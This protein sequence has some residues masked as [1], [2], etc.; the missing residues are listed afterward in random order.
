M[1]ADPAKPIVPVILSGGSGTQLWPLSRRTR[2]KQMLDLAG[3]GTMLALTVARV[4]DAELF[5]PPVLV[6][7]ADQAEAV[8]QALP[9]RAC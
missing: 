2:P 5:A 4:E 6:A 9:K 3:G 7:G 1:S 8:A